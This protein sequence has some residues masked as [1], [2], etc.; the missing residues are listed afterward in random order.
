[1]EKHLK[2]T[3]FNRHNESKTMMK[4]IPFDWGKG[5]IIPIYGKDRKK[6]HKNY[7]DEEKSCLENIKE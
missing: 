5:I 4:T 7:D 6:L 1:M 3:I 2:M